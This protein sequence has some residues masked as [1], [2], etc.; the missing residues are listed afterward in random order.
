MH[1]SV[2]VVLKQFH[3]FSEKLKFFI[4]SDIIKMSSRLTTT[5][6]NQIIRDLIRNRSNLTKKS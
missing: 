4:T 3:E 6:S 2:C 1:K 5:E